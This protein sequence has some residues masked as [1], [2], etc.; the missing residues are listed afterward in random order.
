MQKHYECCLGEIRNVVVNGSRVKQPRWA[1]STRNLQRRS[2]LHLNVLQEQ[3]PRSH[4]GSHFCFAPWA[5]RWISSYTS[6]QGR[7]ISVY[8]S[9]LWHASIRTH[10]NQWLLV[11]YVALRCR[12]A[13]ARIDVKRRIYRFREVWICFSF[14]Q[15]ACLARRIDDQSSII[16]RAASQ[17]TWQRF[18]GHSFGWMSAISH[19]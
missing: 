3:P 4:R 17:G 2:K 11:R 19:R 13:P 15:S 5:A 10:D 14:E 18:R 8:V 1:Y 9:A 6:S 16:L 7:R 12:I